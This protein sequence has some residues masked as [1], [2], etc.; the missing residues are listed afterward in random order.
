MKFWPITK[1][2]VELLGV[3]KTDQISKS[4]HGQTFISTGHVL[5]PG[6]SQKNIYIQQKDDDGN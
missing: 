2:S 6:R 5:H 3:A 1:V 4:E